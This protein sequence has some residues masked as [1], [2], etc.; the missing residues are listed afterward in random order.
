MTGSTLP[1]GALPNGPVDWDRVRL[2]VFDLDGTLYD[3][4]RLRARML[5]RLVADAARRCSLGTIR[6]LRAFRDCRE[7]LG[8]ALATDVAARQYE[9]T[10]ERCGQ[11][12]ESVRKTVEEWIERRPLD[13]LPACRCRGV[14]RVF[15]GLAVQGK[16]IA[17]LSDYP[18]SEKLKALG[19]G[20]S[21]VVSAMD[22]EVG[23]LKPHPA[24][25]AHV[26]NR[27]Q[28]PAEQAIMIGDRVERDWAVAQS[29]GMRALIRSASPIAG[30]DTFRGYDDEIFWPVTEPQP[31]GAP[32]PAPRS[33][34]ISS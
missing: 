21:I 15:A 8:D 16:T 28:V 33:L 11:S 24:G 31:M 13:L 2:V 25:L 9:L 10:A 18:A 12:P 1:N 19:L 32:A 29:H 22:P 30:V 4:R 20:A 34:T 17:V 23:A 27:A 3:Q 7:E 14:E 6:I 26:L 5:L